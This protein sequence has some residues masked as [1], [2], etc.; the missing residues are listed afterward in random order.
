M[1]LRPF[2]GGDAIGAGGFGCVF[3]PPLR[4]ARAAESPGPNYVT[5]LM[6]KDHANDEMNI[7]KH[8]QPRIRA[9]PNYKQYFLVEFQTCSKVAPLTPSDAQSFDQKCRTLKRN[10]GMKDHASINRQLTK[11]GVIHMPYGGIEFSDLQG[12]SAVT[13]EQLDHVYRQMPALLQHGVVEM[14]RRNLYHSD[15]KAENILVTP[16][17][18]QPRIIDWGFAN[19]FVTP[20]PGTKTIAIPSI[21]DGQPFRYNS[22]WMSLLL[23]KDFRREA[24]L[25]TKDW[26]KD[27]MGLVKHLMS[28]V[29]NQF[30]GHRAYTGHMSMWSNATAELFEPPANLQRA[31]K[32]LADQTAAQRDP[33][34]STEYW[35][36]PEYEKRREVAV[37]TLLWPRMAVYLEHAHNK[38]PTRE[39][40]VAKS[41]SHWID[42]WGIVSCYLGL[43][44]ALYRTHMTPYAAQPDTIPALAL[45]NK[46][47]LFMAVRNMLVDTCYTY[48]LV[49][50][51]PRILTHMNA[52]SRALH[53][54]VKL[55]KLPSLSSVPSSPRSAVS[56]PTGLASP[57]MHNTPVRPGTQSNLARAARKSSSPSARST[58]SSVSSRRARSF[59]AV[60]PRSSSSATTSSRTRSGI[61]RVRWATSRSRSGRATKRRRSSSSRRRP[62][63]KRRAAASGTRDHPI[64]LSL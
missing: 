58:H 22:P 30:F 50:N 12:D 60:R 1:S 2:V 19:R 33:T 11:V 44:S 21:W 31:L 43:L 49:P 18:A 6:K 29:E 23:D 5:K 64:S 35:K 53:D 4:C 9:V 46:H 7:L 62:A 55:Q 20:P 34:A 59:R 40:L 51:L 36:Q 39:E 13:W 38:C 63:S 57:V 24:E 27:R 61:Y 10:L 15:V 25:D 3:R 52:V 47:A 48:R 26:S 56:G 16:D 17:A 28:C 8:V 32:T 41:Y 54:V 14:N 45:R 37:Q 42:V